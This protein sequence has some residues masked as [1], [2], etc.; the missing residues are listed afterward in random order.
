MTI[1]AKYTNNAKEQTVRFKSIELLNSFF[2]FTNPATLFG[3]TLCGSLRLNSN[4]FNGIVYLTID[5]TTMTARKCEDKGARLF[6]DHLQ[7][8]YSVVRKF[9]DDSVL[10]TKETELFSSLDLEQVKDFINQYKNQ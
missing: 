1:T 9:D 2:D 6:Y 4:R 3:L 10:H 5:D 8:R 7:E